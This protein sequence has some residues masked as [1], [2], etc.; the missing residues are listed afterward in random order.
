[1]ET[2]ERIIKVEEK[3]DLIM[4]NHLPHLKADIVEVRTDVKWLK[5]WHWAITVPA[6]AGALAGMASI[7]V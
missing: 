1:M 7:F 5:K 2:K 4:S 3:V 6:L